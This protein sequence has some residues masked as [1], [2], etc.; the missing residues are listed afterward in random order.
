VLPMCRLLDHVVMESDLADL[1]LQLPSHAQHVGL[2]GHVAVQ[3][4]WSGSTG[5][6]CTQYQAVQQVTGTGWLFKTSL[7]HV[8]LQW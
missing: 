1:I 7:Q 4:N 6:C 5:S 8:G 3:E 2:Q